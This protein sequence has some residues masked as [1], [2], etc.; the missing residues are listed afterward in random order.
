MRKTFLLIAAAITAS[1]DQVG[2]ATPRNQ[3]DNTTEMALDASEIEDGVVAASSSAPLLEGVITASDG[4]PLKVR[5]RDEGGLAVVGGDMIVGLTSEL[6]DRLE[7]LRDLKD[8]DI[9][10]NNIPSNQKS[11]AERLAKQ[12]LQEGSNVLAAPYLK[13]MPNIFGWGTIGT[14]WPTL[15]IPYEIDVT[16]PVGPRRDNIFAAVGVWNASSPVQ[17]RPSSEVSAVEVQRLGVLKFLDHRND[18]GLFSCSAN[19]GYQSRHRR[20]EVHLNPSCKPG[21]IAHEIG[22]AV[23]LE[24]EHQR[25]DRSAFLSVA[26]DAADAY[27]PIRGRH[28]SSHDLCSL[29]HYS[30][31]VARPPWFTL[32]ATGQAALRSCSAALPNKAECR[33][34]GQRCQLSPTDVTSLK[35]LYR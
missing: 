11:A 32:T 24:H 22:H 14:P 13:T 21:H 7:L 35:L 12:A 15:I 3:I 20:H 9:L 19:V 2:E 30:P 4:W 6:Q 18:D 10:L 23:G 33:E 27:D 17:L 8:G 28:L 25:T 1:C 16:I 5:F 34:V 29:M 26:S 31:K